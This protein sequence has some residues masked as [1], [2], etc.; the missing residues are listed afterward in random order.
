MC[1][2]NF[3]VDQNGN[4]LLWSVYLKGRDGNLRSFSHETHPWTLCG[5]LSGGIQWQE[6][7]PLEGVLCT[8]N[9]RCQVPSPKHHRNNT[10]SVSSVKLLVKMTNAKQKTWDPINFRVLFLYLCLSQFNQAVTMITL[11][12]PK[13]E[14]GT[15]TIPV[16]LRRR[17]Q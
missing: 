12:C 5:N 10:K 15:T 2:N 8:W 9:A 3:P 4:T 13:P 14:P 1:W 16:A 6:S 7:Y 11:T 17:W